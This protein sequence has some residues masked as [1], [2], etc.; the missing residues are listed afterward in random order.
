[1]QKERISILLPPEVIKYLNDKASKEGHSL[2]HE[3]LKRVLANIEGLSEMEWDAGKC[4]WIVVEK[5][6][7]VTA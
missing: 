4:A 2:S 1:M 7:K 3:V 5:Q 6:D